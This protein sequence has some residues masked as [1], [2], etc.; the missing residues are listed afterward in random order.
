MLEI[1]N[2]PLTLPV[3]ALTMIGGVGPEAIAATD[4]R[5]V[6]LFGKAR[7]ERANII[8]DCIAELALAELLLVLGA[9]WLLQ[10]QPRGRRILSLRRRIH[11]ERERERA[12]REIGVRAG[13]PSSSLAVLS[14]KNEGGKW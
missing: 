7:G 8:G 14:K 3:H 12:R 10:Q 1:S 13:C 9:E 6:E 4:L 5:L 11:R 2:A